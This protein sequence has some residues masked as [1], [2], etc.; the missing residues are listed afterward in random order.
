MA[1]LSPI[2]CVRAEDELA[3]VAGLV[4]SDGHL[5]K[6]GYGVDIAT[7]DEKFARK[8]HD[9]L[10]I[11]S[12]KVP[13]ISK[14]R[15]VYVVTVYDRELFKLLTEKFR[16]PRGKKSDIL[17]PP[18]ISEEKEIVGYIRGFFDGDSSVHRR[19]MRTKY[20]PRI[21]AMSQSKKILEWIKECLLKLGIRTGSIFID[22][23]HGFISKKYGVTKVC[24]RLELYGTAVK[25]FDEKIG[26]AHPEKIKKMNELLLL[27]N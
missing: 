8:I 1:S 26:Y 19:R 3:Y 22:K 23:P 7:S 14:K 4:A 9:I 13:K 24:Y 20:V 2:R 17:E 27:L 18:T 25:K 5:T 11:V 21:R 6:S 15:T 10:S 16:I 12:F